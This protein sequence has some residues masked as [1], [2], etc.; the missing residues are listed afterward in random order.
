M[1]TK[2]TL[3]LAAALA[4][5]LASA[6]M[7]QDIADASH[8]EQMD[9]RP[10]ANTHFGNAYGSVVEPGLFQGR[11][12]IIRQAPA[13]NWRDNQVEQNWFNRASEGPVG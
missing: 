3:V 11:D 8:F 1:K 10:Y 7:A 2:T 6:G 5:G 13:Q 4:A 9:V 12:V